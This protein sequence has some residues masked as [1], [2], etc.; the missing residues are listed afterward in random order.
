MPP[1][2]ATP[3]GT[4]TFTTTMFV[5][6]PTSGAGPSLEQTRL[7]VGSIVGG[8]LGGIFLALA[9][10]G[11]WIWWGRAI[12]RHARRQQTPPRKRDPYRE[13]RTGAEVSHAS[14]GGSRQAS[15]RSTPPMGAISQKSV[16]FADEGTESTRTPSPAGSL[17]DEERGRTPPRSAMRSPTPPAT[18][19][20][21]SSERGYA[22]A[23]PSPLRTTGGRSPAVSMRAPS[24]AAPPTGRTKRR[25]SAPPAPPSPM[26]RT[27][28]TESRPR[29]AVSTSAVNRVAP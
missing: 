6:G 8:L 18:R 10:V 16:T 26:P 3:S 12:E 24:P 19:R 20:S 27:M 14:L 13:G 25:Y 21:Q 2:S 15:R 22:P 29:G 11:G 17:R 23:R 9:A 1:A 7:P 28:M 4:A 5:S